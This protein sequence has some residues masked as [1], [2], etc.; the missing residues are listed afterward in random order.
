LEISLQKVIDDES[1]IQPGEEK[2]AALTAGDRIPWAKCRQEYFSKGLNK[3]SLN[4]IEG[5]AFV[6]ALDDEDFNFDPVCNSH[7]NSIKLLLLI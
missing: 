4:V 7:L 5:A 1:T 2:L 6:V 3:V